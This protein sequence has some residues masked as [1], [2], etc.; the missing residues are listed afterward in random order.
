MATFSVIK[1]KGLSTADNQLGGGGDGSLDEADNCIIRYRDVLEPRRGQKYLGQDASSAAA[2]TFGSGSDRST[3]GAFFRDALVAHYGTNKLTRDTGSAFSD[4]SGTYA[5]PD[6]TVLRM[7]FMESVENLYFTTSTGLFVLDALAGTPGAAGVVRAYDVDRIQTALT[8]DPGDGWM[9]PDSRVAYRV[10]WGIKDANGT[11]KYGWPSGRVTVTNPAGF[12]EA[13]GEITCGANFIAV[14]Q[15]NH[16][17]NGSDRIDISPGE[18]NIPAGVYVVDNGTLT[19]NSFHASPVVGLVSGANNTVAQNISSGAKNV[20]LR[21]K[22]PS[23]VTT[24]HYFRLYRSAM[25]AGAML[26]PDDE[27]FLVYEGTVSSS[28]I[29]AGYVDV[30]DLLSEV[31]LDAGFPLYT[32]PNT[33]DGIESANAR[34]PI[35]KDLCYWQDRAWFINTTDRHSFTLK[36]L[37]VGA[38]NGLQNNDTVTIAGTTYTGK[39][40]PG[41]LPEFEVYEFGSPAVNIERTAINLVNAINGYSGNTT[42]TAYYVS[43]DNEAP[44][45][46]E[47]EERTAGGAAFS[48]YASR[49]ASWHPALT[50]GS[51]GAQT[52][53]NSRRP[54]GLTYSKVLQPEAVPLANYVTVGPKHRELLRALPLR[55]KLYVFPEEGGIQTVAGAS[56]PYRVDELDGT[57]WL[58]GADTAVVHANQI[59]ALTNQ[60]VCAI[61]DAGVRI[62]SN[63]IEDELAELLA[64]AGD[65]V[66]QFAFGVSYETER[67]YILFLP[68]SSS[69]TCC[70]QAFVYNSLLDS[71]THWTGSRT[72]G[73]VKPG[74]DVLYLGEGAANTVRLERKDLTRSDYADEALAV[75]VLSVTGKTV[76]LSSVAGIEEGDLLWQSDSIV[77]LVESINTFETSVVLKTTESFAAAAAQVLKA[78]T[79][80]GKYSP[81]VPAGPSINKQ[82]RDCTFHFREYVASLM[83][84]RFDTEKSPTE[85]TEAVPETVGYGV[86][87]FGSTPYGSPSRSPNRRV[88]VP[89]EHQDG[90]QIRVGFTIR[91]AWAVWSLNGYSLEYAGGS[92]RNSR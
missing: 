14:S 2:R 45:K 24:S 43:G 6:P 3:A 25:S 71:W 56:P 65:Q 23:G 91:E 10:I 87:G 41:S 52:S 4:Y 8:G 27:L 31:L 66:R 39:S 20:A 32:N 42:V 11:P 92:E 83:E 58:I 37:G 40:S 61:S 12:T 84:A 89:R 76:R 49:V 5:P 21:V 86:A 78:F 44:G 48:V 72:W 64:E 29:S 38:P 22:I 13:I 60:G 59:L 7:K 47:L 68:S 74:D 88:G 81:A 79:S 82:F 16:G 54:N 73:R 80:S 30:T 15:D 46:I 63:D 9:E 33:G 57:T 17:F 35:A 67:Q 62:V 90:T 26:P 28:D 51:S 19:T 77:G 50:T 34:P 70:T 53:D 85:S 75:T 55:D 1:N 18:A 36:L 69:D